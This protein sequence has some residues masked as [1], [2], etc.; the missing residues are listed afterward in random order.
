[1]SATGTI[2]QSETTPHN[3]AVTTNYADITM[4]PE[5]KRIEGVVESDVAG[6]LNLQ[7]KRLDGSGYSTFQ[8]V[9]VTAGQA[10]IFSFPA[11]AAT[12][13]VSYTV[14]GTNEARH[15]HEIYLSRNL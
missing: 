2:V 9:P 15:S 10:S 1:M 14:G 3:S 11:T 4:V 7:Y 8:S 6:T 5:F 12:V 13:R